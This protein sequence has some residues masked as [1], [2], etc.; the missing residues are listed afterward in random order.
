MKNH[1]F[2]RLCLAFFAAVAP[3]EAWAVVQGT[4]GPTSTF[5]INLQV[6][7]S[8][9]VR[10]FRLTDINLG[11]FDF[12]Q[13]SVSGQ[14]VFCIHDSGAAFPGYTYNVTFDGTNNPGSFELISGGN[15]IPY[16][17]EF[18]DTNTGSGLTAVTA[19]VP[20]TGNSNASVNTGNCTPTGAADNATVRVTVLRADASGSPDGSYSDVLSVTVAPDP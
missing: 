15:T 10:V 14:D 9:R 11:T 16:Q 3:L 2:V 13:P 20:L 18:D 7:V 8:R 12:S 19:G 4:L 6:E 17:V 5:I 1:S